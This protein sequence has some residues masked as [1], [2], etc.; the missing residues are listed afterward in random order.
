MD[1]ISEF[2]RE[3]KRYTKSDLRRIFKLP[4]DYAYVFIKELKAFGV[5]KAVK[6]DSAQRDMSDLVDEDIH[7]VD[8]ET[9][10]DDNLYVFVY[11]GIVTVNNRIIKCYPKYVLS[12]TDLLGEMKQVIKVISRYGSKEQIINLYN[13]DVENSQ[14]NI[15]AVILFLIRD[16]YESGVYNNSEDI[17]E[18]NGEG[19]IIWDKTINEGFSIINNNRPYYMDL[20][21]RKTVDDD[22]DFFKRIHECVLTKC[23]KLLEESD[24]LDIFDIAAIEL[25]EAVL[26]DFGDIDYILYR[27]QAELSIQFNTRKQILLKTLY[28]YIANS[29]ILE[30]SYGLSMYGTNSFNLV[31]EKVCSEVFSN[32]L[33]TPIG[34]IGLPDHLH[35]AYEPHT[36]LIDVIEKPKW[37]GIREDG[38]IF[39]KEVK[40]TLIPDIINI[41]QQEGICQF[42]ILDAKYYNIQ[43]A[44]E[45]QL[46]GQPGVGDVTKQYLYQL[47]YKDFLSNY[48]ITEVK[49]CFLLPTQSSEIV[50]TGVVSMNILSSLELENIQIRQLPAR[51][52]YDYYL[53][54]RTMDVSDLQL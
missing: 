6:N 10:N 51:V 39:D 48:Q 45:K 16:F 2:V 44:E 42:T 36:R 11:V 25:S 13:G 32:K 53:T 7:V 50:K 9:E 21:T 46:R 31:W 43:L 3:Q 52:I 8:V 27:L 1:V 38:S 28:A 19:E 40:D 37:S 5:L 23:S 49:N 17:I 22:F 29:R 24:L 12:E 35:N 4:A 26:D 33:N 54:G 47:A 41:S 20:Y 14:F 18:D 15:L 30:D 34:Q